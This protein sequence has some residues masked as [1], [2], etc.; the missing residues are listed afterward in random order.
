M[1][2]DAPQELILQPAQAHVV[3]ALL[4]HIPLQLLLHA[5]LVALDT[6][7][8]LLRVL[9]H[10]ALKATVARQIIQLRLFNASQEL[11]HHLARQPVHHAPQIHILRRVKVSAHP[12]PQI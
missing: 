4:E 12:M 8:A 5:P 7:L 1:H 10:N 9:G 2:I 11:T 6:I 3:R